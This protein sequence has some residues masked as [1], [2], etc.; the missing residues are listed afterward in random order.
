MGKDK[1]KMKKSKIL[2]RENLVN[3]T[4]FFAVQ[5]IFK[6][7]YAYGQSEKDPTLKRCTQQTTHTHARACS[8]NLAA[9]RM[10]AVATN[11][12]R[13]R[14]TITR[15]NTRSDKVIEDERMRRVTYDESDESREVHKVVE[16]HYLYTAS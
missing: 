1:S 12:R 15:A 14:A 6:L 9:M 11:C 8:L 10:H 5:I 3:P 4:R 16:K 7:A 2:S 13:L